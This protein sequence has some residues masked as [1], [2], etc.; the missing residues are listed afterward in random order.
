MSLSE[1]GQKAGILAFKIR[2]A[3]KKNKMCTCTSKVLFAAPRWSFGCSKVKFRLLQNVLRNDSGQSHRRK[4]SPINRLKILTEFV[5]LGSYL[6]IFS[7]TFLWAFAID[8]FSVRTNVSVVVMGTRSGLVL[9][10]YSEWTVG[11]MFSERDQSAAAAG[12]QAAKK[13]GSVAITGNEGG[14]PR[15]PIAHTAR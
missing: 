5:A 2:G 15:L 1:I 7:R 11:T 3:T 4:R 9:R 14:A 8:R 12:T 6:F 13:D 10:V